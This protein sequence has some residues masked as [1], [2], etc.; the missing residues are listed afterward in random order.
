MGSWGQVFEVNSTNSF[1]KPVPMIFG[2][3]ALCSP[4]SHPSSRYPSGACHHRHT[5]LCIRRSVALEALSAQ[6]YSGRS[7]AQLASQHGI[8]RTQRVGIQRG[9]Q[10]GVLWRHGLLVRLFRMRSARCQ[11]L[12]ATGATRVGPIDEPASHRQPVA[13]G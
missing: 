3:A 8:A 1:Q 2:C 12:P 11:A 9:K 5:L 4:G 7:W 6:Q 10:Y 13:Q